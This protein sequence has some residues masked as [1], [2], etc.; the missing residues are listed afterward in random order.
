MNE[1]DSL[2]GD[3][4]RGGREDL[5][6]AAPSPASHV[7]ASDTETAREVL[8]QAINER[9]SPDRENLSGIR[10]DW[11][12]LDRHIDVLIAAVRAESAWQPIETAPKDG[13]PVLVWL[14]KPSLMR[15][16]HSAI[17][18]DNYRV[19]GHVFDHDLQAKPTYWKPL[20]APPVIGSGNQAAQ[21][22]ASSPRRS[23]AP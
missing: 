2:V 10:E 5:G 21:E 7:G 12:Y 1:N 19:V 22:H 20:P 15:Q 18:K 13:T 14:P 3:D 11:A 17:L 6:P 4:A 8:R 16:V 23:A 9:F